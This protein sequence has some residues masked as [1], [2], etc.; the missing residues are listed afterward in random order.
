MVADKDNCNPLPSC[1]SWASRESSRPTARAT[2][3]STEFRTEYG[4]KLSLTV[5]LDAR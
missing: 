2:G 4:E 1:A 3:P 5:A